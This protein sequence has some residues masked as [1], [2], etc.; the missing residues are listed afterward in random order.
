MISSFALSLVAFPNDGVGS[1]A[2]K[3]FKCNAAETRR[4]SAPAPSCGT[5]TASSQRGM[6]YYTQPPPK[7][8]CYAQQNAT[9]FRPTFSPH[10]TPRPAPCVSSTETRGLHLITGATTAV[11]AEPGGHGSV[12]NL[13]PPVAPSLSRQSCLKDCAASK[14]AFSV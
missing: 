11:A 6:R 10:T 13:L 2:V 12:C 1:V 7:H 14:T 4:Q 8:Y 5:Q 9:A 3:G